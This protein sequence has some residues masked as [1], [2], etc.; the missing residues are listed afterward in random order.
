MTW[1]VV[2]HF[3]SR[4]HVNICG[5]LCV[6]LRGDDADDSEGL[7][8]IRWMTHVQCAYFPATFV[9]V[10]FFMFCFVGLILLG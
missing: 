7:V 6:C 3:A 8:I 9:P 4:V 1:K 2:K 10:R 5:G